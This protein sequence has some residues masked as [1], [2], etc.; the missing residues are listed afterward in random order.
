M[1]LYCNLIATYCKR[2]R[3]D[4]V[5]RGIKLKSLR[6]KCFSVSSK[7]Q[8]GGTPRSAV[9]TQANKSAMSATPHTAKKATTDLDSIDLSNDADTT[10]LVEAVTVLATEVADLRETVE[11]QAQTIEE[12]QDTIEDLRDDLHAEQEQRGQ[13]DAQVRSRLHDIEERVDS[14]EE[15]GSG[16]ANSTEA[17]Q[18]TIQDDDAEPQTDIEQ[19]ARMPDSLLDDQTANVRRAV[20]VASDVEDYT[21]GCPAGRVIRSSE[22]RR[23]LQAGTDCNGHTQTVARVMDLLDRTG[24][25]GTTVVE[26]RGE[27]R[28]VFS[29]DLVDRL[30]ALTRQSHGGDESTVEAT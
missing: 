11:S 8:G 3:S 23:V 22:L 24:G 14:V 13:Q 2:N 26:R 29:D 27:R 21:T 30:S 19:M 28:L 18:T 15:H 25:E 16:H 7:K 4:C 17:G 10:D 1:C 12:Q 9:P 5:R 20:F 6:E